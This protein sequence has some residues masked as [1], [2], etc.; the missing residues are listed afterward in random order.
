MASYAGSR[1]PPGSEDPIIQAFKENPYSD[2]SGVQRQP[3]ELPKLPTKLVRN[4]NAGNDLE[5][6]KY[7]SL[8]DKI[9]FQASWKN[10]VEHVGKDGSP[11]LVVTRETKFWNQK[12]EVLCITRGSNIRR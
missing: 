10:I 2:G 4:L 6:F 3:G 7:P 5:V 11:F 8:G 1:L 9:Y 12:G